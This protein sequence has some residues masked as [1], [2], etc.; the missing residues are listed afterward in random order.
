MFKCG[1]TVTADPD[2]VNKT[3]LKQLGGGKA[4]KSA[5][6]PVTAPADEAE[7][8]DPPEAE[9]PDGEESEDESPPAE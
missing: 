4:T 7:G 2:M 5:P 8:N 1:E 9:G 3:M 6:S